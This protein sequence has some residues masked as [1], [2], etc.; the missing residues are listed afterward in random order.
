M[1]DNGTVQGLRA[2]VGRESN[3]SIF[4]TNRGHREERT[5]RETVNSSGLTREEI[6]R[7]DRCRI[8]SHSAG[9]DTW[10]SLATACA[11]VDRTAERFRVSN[12]LD[13]HAQVKKRDR[14]ESVVD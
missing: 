1:G 2:A 9:R 5:A 12:G 4:D 8:K 14:G 13:Q 6:K 3:A 10:T 11:G 7:L